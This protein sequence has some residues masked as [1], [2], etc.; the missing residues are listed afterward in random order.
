MNKCKAN[1]HQYASGY[2]Y[3]ILD[4]QHIIT[5]DKS[6]FFFTQPTVLK[7]K[8]DANYGKSSTSPHPFLTYKHLDG[9]EATSSSPT[10]VSMRHKH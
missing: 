9:R 1:H 5:E 7:L 3:K 6:S 4:H 8:A 10:P 2:W